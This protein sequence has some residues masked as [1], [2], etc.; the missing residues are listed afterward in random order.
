MS[1]VYMAPSS[2]PVLPQEIS[3]FGAIC[4]IPDLGLESEDVIISVDAAGVLTRGQSDL[5]G[6]G[7][8][9]LVVI[10]VISMSCYHIMMY[11]CPSFVFVLPLVAVS[12]EKKSLLK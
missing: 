1:L 8:A 11:S 2:I 6:N 12:W 9:H 5:G 4:S 3:C 7:R 10:N